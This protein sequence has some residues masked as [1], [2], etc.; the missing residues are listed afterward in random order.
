MEK[1]E[2]KN[3]DIVKSWRKGKKF[4]VYVNG[5]HHFGDS[6]MEDYRSHKSEKRR[7]AYYDRHRKNL[8]GDSDRAKA[9]RIYSKKTW[10]K[11][12]KIE[13][14]FVSLYGYKRYSP[15]L[16]EDMLM[17][18]TP[19]GKIT[20]KDVDFPII[21]IDNQGEAKIMMPEK[22]YNFRGNKVLEIPLKGKM[23]QGGLNR[24]Q[25]FDKTQLSFDEIKE[26]M[27]NR[28]LSLN[29]MRK[30]MPAYRKGGKIKTLNNYIKRYAS[31]GLI[32]GKTPDDYLDKTNKQLSKGQGLIGGV[33]DVAGGVVDFFIPGAGGLVSA[34]LKGIG[35]ATQMLGMK[36]AGIP[37]KIKRARETIAR[38][39]LETMAKQV[40]KY[41]K[42]SLFYV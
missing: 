22:E 30:E 25:S 16:K 42:N 18:N 38:N 32:D 11:G 10:Q 27:R 23:Q 14:D 1:R 37:D 17:I 9:F 7:K 29:A 21:G 41:T 13:N 15:F 26:D 12:G 33:S 5:W 24:M 40:E 4:A 2:G 34:S 28:I 39:E 19:N 8:Q 31:G 36:L 35:S 3:G 6:S 20:M